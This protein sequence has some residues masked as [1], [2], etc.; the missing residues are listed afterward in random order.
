MKLYDKYGNYTSYDISSSNYPVSIYE[1]KRNTICYNFTVDAQ[2][3]ITGITSENGESATFVYNSGLVAQVLIKRE[4]ETLTTVWEVNINYA[5]NLIS[6]ILYRSTKDLTKTF[7]NSYSYDVNNTIFTITENSSG[8]R[9]KC[10]LNESAYQVRLVES[11]ANTNIYSEETYINYS[12]KQTSY[13]DSTGTYYITYDTRDLPSVFMKQVSGG[14]ITSYLYYD[15]NK[16]LCYDSNMQN[17]SK[18][19]VNGN[20]LLNSYFEETYNPWTIDIEHHLG[21]M[22]IINGGVLNLGTKSLSLVNTAIDDSFTVYQIVSFETR[23]TD[24][25]TLNL[26]AVK[27]IITTTPENGVIAIAQIK[28]YNGSTATSDISTI[29]FV[30]ENIW[31]FKSLPIYPTKLYDTVKIE[32][33]VVGQGNSVRFHGICLFQKVNNKSYQY[34]DNNN[35]LTTSYGKRAKSDY[36]NNN[37]NMKNIPKKLLNYDSSLNEVVYDDYLQLTEEKTDFG[38][39]LTRTYNDKNN[40]TQEKEFALNN[41]NFIQTDSIYNSSQNPNLNNEFII[42]S[43]DVNANDKLYNWNELYKVLDDTTDANGTNTEYE[44]DAWN[45][46]SRIIISKDVDEAQVQ[47]IYNG[48]SHVL[49]KMILSNGTAYQFNYDTEWNVTEIWAGK[50]PN[51]INFLLKSYVYETEEGSF[52]GD[53]K[54][55]H[56]GWD[57]IVYIFIYDSYPH[58]ITGVNIKRGEEDEE[59]LF[60]YYYD[61]FKRLRF[62]YDMRETSYGHI[63]YKYDSDNRVCETINPGGLNIKYSYDESSKMVRKCINNLY[64]NYDYLGKSKNVIPDYL[65]NKIKLIYNSNELTRE[66]IVKSCFFSNETNNRLT[67]YCRDVANG[68]TLTEIKSTIEYGESIV[69]IVD[70]KIPCIDYSSSLERLGYAINVNSSNDSQQT[71]ML[72]FK[73]NSIIEGQYIISIG[74]NTTNNFIGIDIGDNNNIFLSAVDNSGKKFKEIIKTPTQVNINEWNFLCLAWQNRPETGPVSPAIGSFK[75]FL[76]DRY[77]FTE[78]TNLSFIFTDALALVNIGC[79]RNNGIINSGTSFNGKI[80]SLIMS[81]GMYWTEGKIKSYYLE[82]HKYLFSDIYNKQ[83][84]DFPSSATT[85]NEF[86]SILA[87]AENDIITLNNNLISMKGVQ[88]NFSGDILGVDYSSNDIFIFNNEIKRY[89]YFANNGDLHYNYNLST[90]GTIAM[91]VYI[92]G[93]SDY[94]FI[95]QNVDINGRTLGLYRNQDKYLCVDFSGGI[96]VTPRVLNDNVWKT[97]S[98][99]WVKTD[100][101]YRINVKIS[102]SSYY[103]FNINMSYSFNNFTTYIGRRKE[104]RVISSDEDTIDSLLGQ[105][106]L[107]TF[108]TIYSSPIQLSVLEDNLISTTKCMEFDEFGRPKWKY[109]TKN[110]AEVLTQ[111][112]VYGNLDGNRISG[113]ITNEIISMNGTWNF[114]YVYDEMGNIILISRN[115]SP[116]RR[117]EYNYR[118]FLIKE[119]I[120]TDSIYFKYQYDGNGNI[121]SKSKYNFSN[122]LLEEEYLYYDYADYPDI[123]T[124][125][126]K[127]SLSKSITYNGEYIGNPQT[128]GSNE[129]NRLA[130]QWEGRKLIGCNGVYFHE[131]YTYNS[132]NLRRTKEWQDYTVTPMKAG[133]NTYW[134]E[135]D[136]LSYEMILDSAGARYNFYMYD[137]NSNLYGIIYNGSRYYY[138]RDILGNIL[139]IVDSSG[140]IVV[141]YQYDAWGRMLSTTGSL[142]ST[143]GV[144]NPFRYKG[145]YY[146]FETGLYYNVTRYYNPEWG[147][148]I[149]ADDVSYLDPSSVNGLNLY[150]YCGNNPVMYSDST[151]NFPVLAF[152][153]IAAILLFTPV[154]GVVTQT[155]VSAVSYVGMAAWA[156]GDLAFNGGQGAWKDMNAIS[157][158]PFNSN[159]ATVLGSSNVSFYKGA[160]V[161]LKNS[162]RSGSFYAISLSKRENADTLR[163]EWGHNV[164]AMIMGPGNYGLTVGVMSPLS[165]RASKWGGYYNSPWE[166]G[167]DMFGGV[168][169]RTHTSAEIS[170][171]KWFVAAGTIFFPAAYLF[172]I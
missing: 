120:F 155:A 3:N 98:M 44:Y 110:D 123:L 125:Y 63:E 94:Q 118:N 21:V 9:L 135:G 104:K 105:I 69:P 70:S 5:N 140:N 99:S 54:E 107:L 82:L 163:H 148:W 164:Q 132:S 129:V 165:M 26:W 166:T 101:T 43:I 143:L 133:S 146:D 114:Q 30:D 45:N 130:Y 19:G 81:E 64:Y 32:L 138:I 41:V 8:R 106:E 50:S 51:S 60:R 77:Y 58:T 47:Y 83:I 13:I 97:V 7:S 79:S 52:H 144:D 160:P 35:I 154:G 53:L 66:N 161:F 172:L 134:Y 153:A 90:E 162:G 147:R 117:Y 46:I 56:Y 96:L 93:D 15:N 157:W 33:K 137:E 74:N 29:T 119:E 102:G 61:E 73:T 28:L 85:H 62:I 16:R 87:Q 89:A 150:A 57:P 115:G 1:K 159:E 103:E 109:I 88:P 168:Q 149:S 116:L 158:N 10:Y 6:G 170:R 75:L 38:S 86:N 156:V 71:I 76:N 31:Q 65:Y 24:S 67:Y 40:I 20:L 14:L 136:L 128:Y 127:G 59:E 42:R 151:G 108:K 2:G 111:R 78:V 124:G 122:V 72:W 23:R 22:E 92:T 95:F 126:R 141:E 17:N 36:Y 167:A 55:L 80:S 48:V 27:E 113:N 49:E 91:R 121:V 4:I 68:N 139:G 37:E 145:Y 100:F 112:Y 12:I 34:D 171:A 39:R 11:N 18:Y 152:L 142:A 84:N 169:G 131:N 25:L